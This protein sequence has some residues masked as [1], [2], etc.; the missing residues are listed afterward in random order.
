MK[1]EVIR[2]DITELEVD[3]VVTAANTALRGGGGVD[4]AVHSAA[5]PDLVKAS[6]ALAPCPPGSA[7]VTPA[8]AM[9][10]RVRWI[11]RAVGPRWRGGRAGEADQLASA[12]RASLAR[13][14]EV[15]ARSVAFPSISTGVYGYPADEAAQVSVTAL[16]HSVSSVERCILVAWN[17]HAARL[18]ERALGSS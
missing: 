11:V 17:E 16:R 9:Q 8:F 14:D 1:I 10:P 5:G 15:S 12:Y 6:R 13:A 7:V 4:G 18:W 2:G 3:A